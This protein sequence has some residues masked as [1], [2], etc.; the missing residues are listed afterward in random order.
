M[1]IRKVFN[2]ICV[3]NFP[4]SWNEVKLRLIFEKYGPI[5]SFKIITSKKDDKSRETKSAHIC[6]ND[7]ADSKVGPASAARAIEL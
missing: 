2:S 3:K 5:S 7:P 4:N 6:Y 1:D